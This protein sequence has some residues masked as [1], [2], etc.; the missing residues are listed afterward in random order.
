MQPTFESSFP[1]RGETAAMT[2]PRKRALDHPAPGKKHKALRRVASPDY[3]NT[4]RAY[5][6]Q[7]LVEYASS[8]AAIGETMAHGGEAARCR[9]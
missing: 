3:L 8:V 5:R 9:L 7:R 1:I 6:L 2:K 4:E